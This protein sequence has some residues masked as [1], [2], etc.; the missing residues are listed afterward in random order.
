MKCGE[1]DPLT[2]YSGLAPMIMN[3]SITISLM[4]ILSVGIFL[5]Q[6][7]IN[8]KDDTSISY[9]CI[10]EYLMQ[11]AGD[12][13]KMTFCCYKRNNTR[14]GLLYDYKNLIESE[15]QRHM[16]LTVV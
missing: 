16:I 1:N 13:C 9:S 11:W 7:L 10:A 14:N 5:N 12:E 6:N 2:P 4:A 15:N 3:K 8:D